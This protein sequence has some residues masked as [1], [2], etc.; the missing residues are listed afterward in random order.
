M[1]Q[2]TCG[3]YWALVIAEIVKKKQVVVYRIA[4]ANE[5]KKKWLDRVQNIGI[6]AGAS[7]PE[8]FIKETR[9]SFNKIVFK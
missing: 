5:I 9:K 8:V 4:N 2:K 1:E 6:N 7:T 3:I